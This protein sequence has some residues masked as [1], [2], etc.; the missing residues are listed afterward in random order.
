MSTDSYLWLNDQQTG[1]YTLTQLRGM[2]VTGAIT[3]AV[4]Y[5]QE[6]M[7]E[8]TP[9][10]KIAPLLE[11]AP[12]PAPVAVRQVDP[13]AQYHTPIQGKKDGNLTPTGLVGILLG[14]VLILMGIVLLSQARNQAEQQTYLGMLMLGVFFAVG[15]FAWA[16][17]K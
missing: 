8:W 12:A 1:P 15:C 7:E 11:Q 6:G 2:W 13:F 14:A 9:L 3:G 17:E 10:S 4:L 5:W 16:R